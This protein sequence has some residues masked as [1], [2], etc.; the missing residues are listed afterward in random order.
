MYIR[1]CVLINCVIYKLYVSHILSYTLYIFIYTYIYIKF[2]IHTDIC[3]IKYI[4]HLH[5][6]IDTHGHI[7]IL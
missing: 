2:D 4:L 5:T 7:Y 6:H 1:I 3:C